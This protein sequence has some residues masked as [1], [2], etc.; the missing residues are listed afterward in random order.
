L[1]LTLNEEGTAMEGVSPVIIAPSPR[2]QALLVGA[3]FPVTAMPPAPAPI[4]AARSQEA[5]AIHRRRQCTALEK[6]FLS[7]QSRLQALDLSTYMLPAFLGVKQLYDELFPD[8][9]WEGNTC[10]ILRYI[11]NSMMGPAGEVSYREPAAA[12]AVA[13]ILHGMARAE[14]VTFTA[15]EDAFKRMRC[16]GL[17][18]TL[19]V[20]LVGDDDADDAIDEADQTG[21]QETEV[22]D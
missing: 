15:T 18:P 9:R 22:R 17:R 6:S 11:R 19:K 5:V 3:R 7:F 1:D 10:I 16:V 20:D 21:G 12:P 8:E 13:E 2:A 4:S 14:A